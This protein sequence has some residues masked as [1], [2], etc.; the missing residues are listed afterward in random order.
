VT[1]R[2]LPSLTG[3]LMPAPP[4]GGRWREES[5]RP[6]PLGAGWSYSPW[7][8]IDALGATWNSI[9]ARLLDG[10]TYGF[11]DFIAHNVLINDRLTPEEA[12]CTAAHEVAHLER[13]R[14]A[15]EV[16]D[17]EEHIVNLV[18]TLRVMPVEA[19]RGLAE[20][21]R[22]CGVEQVA[23]NYGVDPWTIETAL[24]LV[25]LVCAV[26]VSD[27][28]RTYQLRAVLEAAA[29]QVDSP[30]VNVDA[31]RASGDVQ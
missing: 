20:E 17:I 13:G 28:M 29:R 10:T 26:D 3:R 4:S 30:V 31:S 9:D 7:R 14:A 8:H 6:E 21:V 22:H 2:A 19:F 12:R 15:A 27:P 25:P 5:E 11:A 16:S 23:Q 18:A 1:A 24:G